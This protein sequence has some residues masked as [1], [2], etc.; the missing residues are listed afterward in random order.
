MTR[1]GPSQ[2]QSTT[3]FIRRGQE[4]WYLST[5]PSSSVDLLITQPPCRYGSAAL[6]TWVARWL[7]AACACV[8]PGGAIVV[9]VGSGREEH[10]AYQR[11]RGRFARKLA[12]VEKPCPDASTVRQ[13]VR[14]FT[15]LGDRVLDPFARRGALLLEAARL[16][17]RAHGCVQSD[18]ELRSAAALGC[19]VRGH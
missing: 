15:R 13:V 18:E 10:D 8:R 9:F 5:V 11:C 3:P 12:L 14:H 7:D 4:L 6:T 19:V 16:G 17:R 2:V 1:C